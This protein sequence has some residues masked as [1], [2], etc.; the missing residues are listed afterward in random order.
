MNGSEHRSDALDFQIGENLNCGMP[1][2][3]TLL[4]VLGQDCTFG[5]AGPHLWN[6]PWHPGVPWEGLG[7]RLLVAPVG[8][9]LDAMIQVC[10]FLIL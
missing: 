8:F 10:P 2:P 7:L 3:Q 5:A 9:P 6:S 4:A 1:T